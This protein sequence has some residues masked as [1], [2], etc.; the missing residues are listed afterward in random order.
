MLRIDAFGPAERAP[1]LRQKCGRKAYAGHVRKHH[2][3]P[4]LSVDIQ[5]FVTIV[6][7]GEASQLHMKQV[8]NVENFSVAFVWRPAEDDIAPGAF[9]PRAELADIE[10]TELAE[11]GQ[12][13]D[14]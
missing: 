14:D 12:P 11:N 5:A 9:H 13:P 2:K 8:S 1:L 10:A 4:A 7:C 6:S 3:H